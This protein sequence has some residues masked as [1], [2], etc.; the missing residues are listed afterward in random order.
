MAQASTHQDKLSSQ[1]R[2]Q[3]ALQRNK[4]K[5]LHFRHIKPIRKRILRNCLVMLLKLLGKHIVIP[6]ETQI[7]K[8]MF[9]YIFKNAMLTYLVSPSCSV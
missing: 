6:I 3:D 7:L 4:T 5:K 1:R 9:G 8:D 2:F